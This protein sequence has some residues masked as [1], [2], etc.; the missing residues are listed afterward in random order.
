MTVPQA[1]KSAE[2]SAQLGDPQT[3]V[4]R[5][6]TA[7]LGLRGDPGSAWSWTT[8]SEVSPHRGTRSIETGDFAELPL[9]VGRDVEIHSYRAPR[10]RIVDRHV[11]AV[12]RALTLRDHLAGH[13]VIVGD[14]E[15]AAGLIDRV[16]DSHSLVAPRTRDAF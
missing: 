12:D 10:V 15:L 9:T 4:S 7:G 8:R 2:L 3:H 16:A 11:V 13:R 5:K 6:R 1:S 14:L